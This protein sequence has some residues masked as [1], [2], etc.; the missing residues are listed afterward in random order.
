MPNAGVLPSLSIV[1]PNFNQ[2]DLLRRCLASIERHAPHGTEIIVVDDGSADGS[3]A[4]VRAEFPS[5][6]LIELSNNRGFCT[7][8][9]AGWRSARSPIVELLN[10]DAEV[11][12]GWAVPALQEFADNRV[13]SVAPL[14]RRLPFR[15]RIDSA[16]D[17]L[18]LIGVARKRF[19]GRSWLSVELCR[20]EV[21]SAS[22]SSAFYRRSALQEVGGFPEEYVSYFDDVDLGYRLR[23]AGWS[24]V[25]APESQVLH[26]VGRSHYHARRSTQHQVARN[27][28]RFFWTNVPSKEL[29]LKAFPRMAYILA[30]LTYKG[31]RGEFGPWFA[32][33]AS[34][35]GEIP[36]LWTKRQWAQQLRQS[37]PNQ[38]VRH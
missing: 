25:L 33:K 11:T 34:L 10:N 22:A 19:E 36:N 15:S 30:L 31:L 24:S 37:R 27:S 35:L 7:A 21:F 26:W 1:I 12:S 17:V 4:M 13:G 2:A 29:A 14:V 32:G 38:G 5:V 9:N 16:G 18:D 6:R 8:A 23:L 28:E 20:Q 3:P